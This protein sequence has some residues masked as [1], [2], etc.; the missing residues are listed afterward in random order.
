MVV[1]DSLRWDYWVKHFPLPIGEEYR[2]VTNGL[3][4]PTSMA[5]ILTGNLPIRTGVHCFE[6][7]M[8]GKN[9]ISMLSDMGY[10][11]RFNELTIYEDIHDGRHTEG[12][13]FPYFFKISGLKLEKKKPLYEIIAE[14]LPSFT[15]IHCMHTHVPYNKGAD[16]LP[17]KME[18][19][20]KSG[21]LSRAELA[22]YY[23]ESVGIWY[24]KWHAFMDYIDGLG[25]DDI[26]VI[27]LS[28]HGEMLLEN[29]GQIDR[30]WHNYDFYPE[31]IYVPVVWYYRGCEKV[32]R[33]EY[34]VRHVDILPE[35]MKRLGGEV[36]KDING[37]PYTNKMI[38]SGIWAAFNY[39]CAVEFNNIIY[40]PSDARQMFNKIPLPRFR[41]DPNM[42]E[43]MILDGMGTEIFIHADGR[44]VQ[45]H[46]V[47]RNIFRRALLK[48]KAVPEWNGIP[49][50]APIVD[51]SDV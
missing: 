10:K 13:S 37:L 27:M 44:G 12:L 30:Y 17:E 33:T 4:T 46:D 18:K 51:E 5:S 9:M 3:W 39:G 29:Y 32:R 47:M 2:S 50:N 23:D 35:M 20:I 7:I 34:R 40:S 19:K 1:A 25:R 26:L 14:D 28:D 22:G 6:D 43:N 41:E 16:M 11:C 49:K 36:P 42:I 48:F 31:M 8:R 38:F 24:E 45:A 15:W 21:E